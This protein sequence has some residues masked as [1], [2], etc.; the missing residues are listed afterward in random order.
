M[1]SIDLWTNIGSRKAEIFMVISEK[2]LLGLSVI[3][4]A[5]LLQQSPVRT[6]VIFSQLLYK[7]SMKHLLSLRLRYFFEYAE[8]TAVAKQNDELIIDLVNK[9][10]A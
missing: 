6:K 1:V 7:D 4:I 8:L 10:Q 3:T 2:A 5:G 9:A